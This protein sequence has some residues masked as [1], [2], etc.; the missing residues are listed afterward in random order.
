MNVRLRPLGLVPIGSSKA[1][2]KRLAQSA[3]TRDD[4]APTTRSS[5]RSAT[6]YASCELRTSCLTVLTRAS[7]AWDAACRTIPGRVISDCP[8]QT[9][10]P[11]PDFVGLQEIVIR[12]C[13]ADSK[14]RRKSSI[15]N[16]KLVG[17]PGFE[18]GASRSRTVSV[19]CPPVSGR[20]PPSS[21]RIPSRPAW[22]PLVTP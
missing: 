20:L 17:G 12:P 16:A 19:P 6:G 2:P 4:L 18:P 13:A 22:C 21:S 9:P 1:T 11:R 7:A 8:R 14:P 15:L 3:R 10:L 5:S